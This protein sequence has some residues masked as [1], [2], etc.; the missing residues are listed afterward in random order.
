MRIF[1]TGGT[2]L[3]GRRLLKLLVGRGDEVYLLTRRPTVA[4][5]L[6]GST[7]KAVE[8]DPMQLGEW[9]KAI[10]DCDAV[11]NLAGENIFAKRWSAQFKTL[12]HDSRVK[13]TQHV[14]QAIA[15]KPK[16]SDGQPKVL[17]NANA[18]GFYGPHGD[19]ELTEDS[20][21]GSDFMAQIC[22]DWEKAARAVEAAGVRCAIVRVGV[23]LDKDGGALR[24]MM[25][26]F[27]FGVGGPVGSGKQYLS[28]IH[29]EDMTGILLFALDNAAVTGPINATAPN[30]VTNKAFGK[31]LGAAL[32]RPLF[33]WTPGLMLRLGL[34]E[35]ADL[36][37]V[38]QRVIP[39]KAMTLGY[40]FKFPTIEVALTNIL[41]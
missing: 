21:C 38:G 29:H 33:V 11:I 35:V 9:M 3:I 40:P 25:T 18:I 14:V 5:E 39:K 23:V 32:H 17:V 30:P 12:L 36:I 16:R 34:G 1:V 19:E 2:G 22:I 10:D 37:T 28:W 26:P 6:F 20:P 4:Q 13:S 15:V 41:G 7:C 27:V 24:K 8:G 31:T